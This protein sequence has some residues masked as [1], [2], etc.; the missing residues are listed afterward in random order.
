VIITTEPVDQQLLEL[1][2]LDAGKIGLLLVR[3]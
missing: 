1:L 2:G 3:R